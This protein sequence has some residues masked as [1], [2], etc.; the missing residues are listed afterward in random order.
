M[1]DD[2]CSFVIRFDSDTNSAG[3]SGLF[4]CAL[5]LDAPEMTGKGAGC[6]WPDART[7]VGIVGAFDVTQDM[8][9]G[10]GTSVS[11]RGGLIRP[12][13]GDSTPLAQTNVTLQ[14]PLLPIAPILVLDV[15]NEIYMHETLVLDAS[16]S[17][18][19]GTG[20]SSSLA[21]LSLCLSSYSFSL[22]LSLL[23]FS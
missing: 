6:Y 19:A 15:P 10:V 1:Q 20:Y 11:F 21:L 4:D 17:T 13:M 18:G 12:K 5:L 16:A 2:L 23:P 7:L 9:V 8:P 3:L 14:S 22:S